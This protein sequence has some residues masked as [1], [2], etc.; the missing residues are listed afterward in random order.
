M[1]Q[2]SRN[3]YGTTSYLAQ[4]AWIESDS[5]ESMSQA[6]ILK[7]NSTINT[8]GMGLSPGQQKPEQITPLCHPHLNTS[9]GITD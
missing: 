4:T 2:E 1:E 8:H 5:P 7:Q 9:I 6:R 3:L